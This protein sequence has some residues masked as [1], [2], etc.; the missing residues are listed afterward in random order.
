M[1]NGIGIQ[2]AAADPFPSR[3]IDS[4]TDNAPHPVHLPPEQ[5]AKRKETGCAGQLVQIEWHLMGRPS[6][7]VQGHITH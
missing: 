7:Y 6:P 2:P 3:G 4:G 1:G 5:K